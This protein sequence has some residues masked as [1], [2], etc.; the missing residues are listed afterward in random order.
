MKFKLSLK[1]KKLWQI[2]LLSAICCALVYFYYRLFYEYVP[3]L[4][5]TKNILFDSDTNERVFSVQ[6][7]QRHLLFH[8]ISSFLNKFSYKFL[9]PFY[10]AKLNSAI[11]GM[12]AS[13]IIFFISR[14]LS[15]SY[16]ISILLLLSYALSATILIFSSIPESFMTSAFMTNLLI[17]LYLYSDVTKIKY[18]IILGIVVAASCFASGHHLLTMVFTFF[19]IFFKN[20][21]NNKFYIKHSAIFLITCFLLIL[22]PIVLYSIFIPKDYN[23]FLWH[24]RHQLRY[25]RLQDLLQFTAWKPT[26][27]NFFLFSISPPNWPLATGGDIPIESFIAY[28]TQLP[29]LGF[30]ITYGM[31]LAISIKKLYDYRRACHDVFA[32]YILGFIYLVFFVAFY[33]YSAFT[34]ASFF[35]FFQICII[36]KGVSFIKSR[37]IYIILSLFVIFIS[38]GNIT[39][40]KNAR[41]HIVLE[42]YKIIKDK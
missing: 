42:K 37:L 39:F 4:T 22:L 26:L 13:L 19:Y 8:I 33:S 41:D 40:L 17:L 5:R 3:F 27:T 34:F 2:L 1:N 15:L 36:A 24:F 10:S 25:F 14:K 32:V 21:R 20:F 28:F 7:H 12:S 18:C 38:I 29:G 9:D 31:L 23:N 6:I 35:L 30:I 11:M 16:S